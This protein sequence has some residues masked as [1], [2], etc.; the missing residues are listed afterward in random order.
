VIY[1]AERLLR[2]WRWIV[3][4]HRVRPDESVE[5]GEDLALFIAH[6]DANA[7]RAAG[8]EAIVEGLERL[9]G[10]FSL[11]RE[12]VGALAHQAEHDVEILGRRAGCAFAEIVHARDEEDMTFGGAGSARAGPAAS[13]RQ[14]V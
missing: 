10:G 11:H 2:K 5:T 3:D 1:Y 14:R 6:E 4:E 9:V 13:R 7:L 12:A 8:D